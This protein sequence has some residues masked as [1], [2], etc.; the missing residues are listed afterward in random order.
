MW[1]FVQKK[2]NKQWIWLAMDA[3]FHP[4]QYEVYKGVM[5]AE[6]HIAIT[7][8]A[9]KTSHIERFNNT[10]RQRLSRLVHDL[11][12]SPRRLRTTSVQS[13]SL[14]VMTTRKKRQHYLCT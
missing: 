14:Y 11:C 9:C 10:L 2:T 6:R 13:S 1:S 4:D 3:T 12:P 5:P 8:K 7:K